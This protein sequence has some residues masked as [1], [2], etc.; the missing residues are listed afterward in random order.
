MLNQLCPPLRFGLIQEQVY[1]S[2]YP[3]LR[4]LRHLNR[5]K[6]KTIISLIPEAPTSDLVSFTSVAGIDLIHISL[7]RTA[8]LNQSLQVSL[9]TA[10]NLLIDKS[11]HP[12]LIH[13]LDGRRITGLL[14]LLLR[15]LQGWPPVAALAEFWKYQA[16]SKQQVSEIERT[17]REIEKFALEM[18]DVIITDRIPKWLWEGKRNNYV[19][20]IKMKHVPALESSITTTNPSAVQAEAINRGTSATPIA[21]SEMTNN[22]KSA[23][24]VTNKIVRQV[25]ED[26]LRTDETSRDVSRSVDALSLHGLDVKSKKGKK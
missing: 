6:L 3:C 11:K 19:P 10:L 2:G 8:T 26:L 16:S 22:D 1:R 17:T 18:S 7:L 20:G 25:N 13:C 12:I 21:T 24:G 23:S 4:N 9:V 5:L 14:V 15:R